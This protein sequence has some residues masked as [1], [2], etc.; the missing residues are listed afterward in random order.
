[1][2]VQKTFAQVRLKTFMRVDLRLKTFMQ[3]QKHYFYAIERLTKNMQVRK[4]FMQIRLKTFM[5]VQKT[6]MER[7]E[8]EMQRE[9]EGRTE[10]RIK[11]VMN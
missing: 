8:E 5:Q 2:Q 10:C 1:M 11:R 9:Q 7:M 3:V 6:E 4:T